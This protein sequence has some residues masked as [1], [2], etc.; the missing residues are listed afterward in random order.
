MATS[1]LNPSEKAA[2][3]EMAKPGGQMTS[4]GEDPNQKEA[5][6][7]DIKKAYRKLSLKFHPDKCKYLHIGKNEP[8]TNFQYKLMG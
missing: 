2:S 6:T 7:D 8:D 1:G 4:P 3:E 5:S